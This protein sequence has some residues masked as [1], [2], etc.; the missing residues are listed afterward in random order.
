LGLSGCANWEPGPLHPSRLLF[1]GTVFSRDYQSRQQGGNGQSPSIAG[2]SGIR[3]LVVQ[4]SFCETANSFD[5]NTMSSTNVKKEFN[6]GEPLNFVVKFNSLK[7]GEVRLCVLEKEN[8]KKVYEKYK[9]IKEAKGVNV[10][11]EKE[12]TRTFSQ[13]GDSFDYYWKLGDEIMTNSY[14]KI[15]KN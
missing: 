9:G 7:S 14:F 6:I 1:D 8:G 10:F 4:K 2:N 11:F 13:Y 5:F 12:D 3:L 15:I